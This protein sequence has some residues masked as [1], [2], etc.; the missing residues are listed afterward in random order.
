MN[1]FPSEYRFSQIFF[2]SRYVFCVTEV[3]LIGPA[4]IIYTKM[5]DRKLAVLVFH[6]QKLSIA[7]EQ[8]NRA[9]EGRAYNNLGVAYFHLGDFQ[10]A[11][12]CYTKSLNIAKEQGNR[13]GEGR[14][15]YNLGFTYFYL[16]DFQ[17][18]IEYCTQLL[19]I[20]QEVGH[21]EWEG[22]AA[23]ILA[24][25]Y[26]LLDDFKK[27]IEYYTKSLSF[28]KGVWGGILQ[29]KIYHNL[30][31]S[32]YSLGDFKQ[33]IECHKKDLSI[34]KALGNRANEGRAYGNLGV[35]QSKLGNF[36][37]AIECHRRQLSIAREVDDR[38]DEGRAYGNLG[39]ADR[40]MGNF[41]QAIEYFEQ[42]LS[43]AKELGDRRG[44]GVTYGNLG[45]AYFC[46]GN[47]KQAIE[48]HK[49]HL[50]IA[51]EV[52]D[53]AREGAG[54]CNLG[55]DYHGLGN[56]RQAVE[57]H[58]QYL[59]IVKEIG[60]RFGEGT[61]YSNLG[62]A[63]N[64]VRNFKQ[65]IEYQKKH[66]SIA[67]DVGSMV[68]EGNAYARLGHAYQELGD[69]EKAVEYFK[70][71]L[72]I[73]KQIGD[74]AGEGK[75]QKCLGSAYHSLGNSKHAI[76]YHE[77]SL[78]I[79]KEVGD[80]V[81]EGDAYCSLGL[82]YESSASFSEAIDCYQSSIRVLEKTRTL[83]QSEDAWQ[84]SFRD[85]HQFAYNAL[86][87]PLLKNGKPC[88]A[89]C[90]AE[91][92]RAQALMDMLKRRY[93]VDSK[94]SASDDPNEMI[95]IL[96][97]DLTAQTG[98]VALEERVDKDTIHFWVLTKSREIMTMQKEI[99][100][101]DA[102][103]L[104]EATL[105][106]IDA[107]VRVRCENRSMDELRDEPLSTREDAEEKDQS[108][109][110]SVNS[111]CPLYDVIIGPIAEL[112][113]GEQLIVVPDGPLCLAPYS[114]LSETIR[115]RTVPSL[116]TLK[117]ITG[118]PDDFHNKSEVLLVGDPCLEEVTFR[119]DEPILEQLP[120]A[121][122]E[123][124]EIGEI[125]KTTPLTGKDAIKDEV[126]KRLKSVALVHI[127]AHGCAQTGEIVLTPN[128]HRSSQIPRKQDYI[129]TMSDVQAVCLR[130]CLVVLSCCHSG[131]GEVKSEGVVGIARSFLC[132]GARSV[133]VSLWA[134]DD[135]A[136]MVFMKSFYQ[137]LA[138]GKSA[139][140][141]LHQAMKSLRESEKF[142]AVKYWAPFVL[143]GDDVTLQFGGKKQ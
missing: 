44:E 42:D 121:R 62:S 47:L 142:S 73:A 114:A 140:V 79:A 112:L 117:L 1:N 105:K 27:A 120:F 119:Y 29:G 102:S 71:Y 138:E 35:A 46:L 134:I 93:V 23:C 96:L 122:K 126:V 40:G 56:F 69:F 52:G 4:I 20:A 67:K 111:L 6:V 50:N 124:E 76:E 128:P 88:E 7:K 22:V 13:A 86:W 68:G 58:E 41:K 11:I 38:V 64:S 87:R 98:F 132:A 127:A 135:E 107:G 95:S 28:T 60:D 84:I 143:I 32:Y 92:G 18:A 55:S 51:K 104:I 15:Y 25:A 31:L 109:S 36:K 39:I 133:L 53:R 74:R 61:A 70:Q 8:A 9:G 113:Q 54:Y 48:Y 85:L 21:K 90:A 99:E 91:Q 63:Y 131:R 81:E 110:S 78:S 97:N 136:T 65:A 5:V 43:I 129:L 141:A 24:D 16:G 45:N 101:G 49:Q 59:A 72:S 108:W 34:A 37:Q 10:Q 83:L 139:S 82:D 2:P 75:A 57:Y 17:Q 106:E 125:L 116:T 14:A 118:L 33:A 66:L 19:S 137:H 26:Y 89:L 30:G 123:V 115:I 94:P 12:E 3:H 130:A 80:M 103:M 77:K 100:H